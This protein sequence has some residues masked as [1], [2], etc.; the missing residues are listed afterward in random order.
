MLRAGMAVRASRPARPNGPGGRQRDP[1]TAAPAAVLRGHTIRRRLAKAPGA[2]GRQ[3]P[4]AGAQP[5]DRG[6]DAQRRA[7]RRPFERLS[8]RAVLQPTHAVTL[9]LAL[10]GRLA[11]RRAGLWPTRMARTGRS[12]HRA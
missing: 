9:R 6:A 3:A 11:R 7:L 8:G 4:A 10:P 1:T 12:W 2:A 5:A